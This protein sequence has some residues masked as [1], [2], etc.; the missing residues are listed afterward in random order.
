[1]EKS[2]RRFLAYEIAVGAIA[3]S[4]VGWLV[5]SRNLSIL[6]AIVAACA[7]GA[8]AGAVGRIA[9]WVYTRKGDRLI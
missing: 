4:I 8:C 5:G 6:E 7:I 1:M 3:G 2:T 9:L